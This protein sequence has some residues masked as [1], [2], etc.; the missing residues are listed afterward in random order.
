MRHEPKKRGERG[1]KNR[2]DADPEPDGPARRSGWFVRLEN[3]VI[4]HIRHEFT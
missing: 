1:N 4:R 2:R 3:F